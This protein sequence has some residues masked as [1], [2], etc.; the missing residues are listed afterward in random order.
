[1]IRPAPRAFMSGLAACAHH[2][3]A[4]TLASKMTR[5]SSSLMDSRGAPGLTAHS[6]G[7]RYKTI[8]ATKLL[9]DGSDGILSTAAGAKI[10]PDAG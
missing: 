5:Q 10:G 9:D 4:S 3:A 7:G 6:A 8:N 1:M 2:M